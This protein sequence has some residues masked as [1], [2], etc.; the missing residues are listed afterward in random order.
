MSWTAPSTPVAFLEV[1]GDSMPA[2]AGLDQRQEGFAA[3]LCSPFCESHYQIM[4]G[5][6]TRYKAQDVD[7]ADGGETW[8]V[9][10][11]CPAT[12]PPPQQ[13]VSS[14]LGTSSPPLTEMPRKGRKGMTARLRGQG[15]M[16]Q[17]WR[18]SGRTAPDRHP[19]RLE[20]PLPSTN[21][22]R[23]APSTSP[24]QARALE[25]YEGAGLGYIAGDRD[26]SP[27]WIYPQGPDGWEQA[28]TW[29]AG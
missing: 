11:T 27:I 6:T 24:R 25:R 10:T 22:G 9:E 28:S 29:T 13:G 4:L 23:G 5:S 14:S 17:T 19:E 16:R 20:G 15:S 2:T 1:E 18:P 8:R 21:P 3:R 26:W 7:W 12:R